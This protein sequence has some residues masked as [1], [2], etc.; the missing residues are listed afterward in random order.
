MAAWVGLYGIDKIAESIKT[1][2]IRI[3]VLIM[4]LQNGE[5][6]GWLRDLYTLTT[7]LSLYSRQQREE[8]GSCTSGGW[9]CETSSGD[10]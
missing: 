6:I 3:L 9:P 7:A 1:N 5:S 2:R 4:A 8:E 10:R